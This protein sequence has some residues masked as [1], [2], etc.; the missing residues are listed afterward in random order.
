M[1]SQTENRYGVLTP[2]IICAIFTLLSTQPTFYQHPLQGFLF[3][4][5]KPLTLSHFENTIYPE[6][7]A[8]LNKK[9]LRQISFSLVTTLLLQ[10][11]KT[12]GSYEI[13]FAHNFS[14]KKYI[15]KFKFNYRSYFLQEIKDYQILPV[16]KDLNK[17]AIKALFLLIGI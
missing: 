13:L 10:E 8:S 1:N 15:K 2:A 12:K 11:N 17:I 4:N 5:A 9:K 3:V 14:L 16:D 7:F 6:F